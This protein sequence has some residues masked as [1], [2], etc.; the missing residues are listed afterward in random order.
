[1]KIVRAKHLLNTCRRVDSP[2]PQW[3]GDSIRD[4]VQRAR[5]RASRAH[6]PEVDGVGDGLRRVA[7]V[8][9]AVPKPAGG[10]RTP[11]KGLAIGPYA[12]RV[13]C[14]RTYRQDV[15]VVGDDLRR[16]VVVVVAVPKLA[17]S[18]PTKDGVTQK[19]PYRWASAMV[20]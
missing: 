13:S 20:A 15:A 18:T 9:A 1:M 3:Q 6:R 8:I 10:S 12:A 17:A 2:D 11:T 7:V 19:L 16:V 14:S 5:V 4:P